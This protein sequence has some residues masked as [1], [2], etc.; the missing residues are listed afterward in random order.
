MPRR[1]HDDLKSGGKRDLKTLK[2]RLEK[3]TEKSDASARGLLVGGAVLESQLQETQ[4]ELEALKD[5]LRDLYNDSIS[6]D[7]AREFT[8]SVQNRLQALIASWGE[9]PMSPQEYMEKQRREEEEA[10]DRQELERLAKKLGKQ[11]V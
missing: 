11:I 5:F 8:L 4:S 3:K 1:D 7:D 9:K 10:R 6:C 2:E